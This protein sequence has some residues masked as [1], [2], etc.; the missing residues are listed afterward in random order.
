MTVSKWTAAGVLA[1]TLLLGLAV[2]RF[3]LPSKT[4]EKDHIVTSDREVESSFHAYVGHI[5]IKT[6]TKVQWQTVTK[7]EKDGTV[8]QTVAAVSQQEQATKSDTNEQESQIR[9]VVKYQ[10]VTHEKIVEAKKPDWI[11]GAGAGINFDR[12]DL[13]YQADVSRRIIGPVFA[14]GWGEKSTR[15]WAAGVGVKLLF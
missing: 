4:I 2:G 9:E 10:E 6:D 8:T 13:I 15:G 5:E 14:T 1:A 3:T 7:W 12:H 11:L